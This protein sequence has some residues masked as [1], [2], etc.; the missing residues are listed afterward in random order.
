MTRGYKRGQ[1][2]H[3][4]AAD[5]QS[6]GAFR[7]PAPL[8]EPVHHG[9]FHRGRPR[10]AQ[11]RSVEDVESRGQRVRHHAHEVRRRRHEG[12]KARM[13]DIH[14]VRENI[15]L[16]AREGL[17]ERN[18][19]RGRRFKERRPQKRRIALRAHWLVAKA[20]E[21]IGYQIDHTVAHGPHFIGRNFKVVFNQSSC[22]PSRPTSGTKR[23]PEAKRVVILPFS[24]RTTFRS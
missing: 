13:A 11:P 18:R 3:R 5:E 12:E 21:M 4:S 24:L 17:I 9:Q 1:V 15:A 10:P 2:R 20:R 6:A 8:A 7:K 14:D 22:H 16:Q 19:G 23:Q